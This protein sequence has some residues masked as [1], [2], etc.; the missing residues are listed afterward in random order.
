MLGRLVSI[1]EGSTP[2]IVLSLSSKHAPHPFAIE[3]WSATHVL[4]MDLYTAIAR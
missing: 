1:Q 2:G 3:R 4:E